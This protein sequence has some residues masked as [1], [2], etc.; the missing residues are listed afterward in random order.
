MLSAASRAS[1]PLD[2]AD[3]L[4]A[5]AHVHAPRSPC[6]ALIGCLCLGPVARQQPLSGQAHV[7][8]NLKE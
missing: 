6:P 5:R 1:L 4:L 7:I 3:D 2:P 8:A